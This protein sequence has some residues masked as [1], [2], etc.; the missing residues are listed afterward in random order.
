MM[1]DI[2]AD[3]KI[4]WNYHR[5][6]LPVRPADTIIAFGSHDIHVA[7]RAAGLFMKGCAKRII[8]TGGL[9][10]ITKK[11]WQMPESEKFARIA[12]AAGV[13]PESIITE[14]RSSNTGENIEFTK[15]KLAKLDIAP[16]RC[17]AV[18][19]P[20]RER[21]T[22]AALKKQWPQLDFSI[23]SPQYTYE[24]YC[25]FYTAPVSLHTHPGI[26]FDDFINIMVGDLQRIGIYGRNGYQIPQPIPQEAADAF[27]RLVARGYD[28]MLVIN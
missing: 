24:D 22:Y 3:A 13:P 4:L 15:K 21:R 16:G 2:N 19:K 10:R 18:D 1:Y 27:N 11:I 7:E 28:K 9:G 12:E 23:T 8:F 17:I 26:S 6:D 20:Y 5:L 25:S 14:T